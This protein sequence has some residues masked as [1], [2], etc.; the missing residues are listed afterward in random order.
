[1]RLIGKKCMLAPL[2]SRR[3]EAPEV[4]SPSE[5]ETFGKWIIV[6]HF[7]VIVIHG[8]RELGVLPIEDSG[9]MLGPRKRR[10]EWPHGQPKIHHPIA[11]RHL[12]A[13]MATVDPWSIAGDFVA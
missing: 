3:L 1:M 4:V 5:S 13:A 9:P 6:I 11:L 2:P 12:S 8:E 10:I 7:D